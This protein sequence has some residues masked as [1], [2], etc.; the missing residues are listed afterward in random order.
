MPDSRRQGDEF[1][2]AAARQIG[3][4]VAGF[5]LHQA[6][7]IGFA[8]ARTPGGNNVNVDRAES[9]VG[10]ALQ[11]GTMGA[12]VGGPIGAVIGGLAGA[13]AGLAR[14]ETEL[15]NR[16]ADNVIA[17]QDTVYRAN[18]SSTTRASDAAF[19]E[20]LR[21]RTSEERTAMLE[22]RRQEI[23]GGEGQWSI[24]NLEASS[25]RREAAGDVQSHEYRT[26]TAN[27]EMQRQR[28][29]ALTDQIIAARVE[30]SAPEAVRAE[31]LTDAYSKKGLFAGGDVASA[32][33]NE[34]IS[35]GR[36]QVELLKRIAAMGASSIYKSEAVERAATFE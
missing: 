5:A 8:A 30:G 12:M 27:L 31:D 7:S 22:A 11:Y 32:A 2:R 15:R 19:S 24:A 26:E 29:A 36:E 4:A 23:R 13:V 33:L 3:R 25:R 9:A 35:I 20:L 17:R 10:G 16:I 34:Q 14:H 1:G 28:E 21:G 18:V 6:A